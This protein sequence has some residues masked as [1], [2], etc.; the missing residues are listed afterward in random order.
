MSGDSYHR[1][2]RASDYKAEDLPQ[3]LQDL[4]PLTPEEAASLNPRKFDLD[5][6]PLMIPYVMVLVKNGIEC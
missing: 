3:R 5:K 1:F 2:Q 6:I 4:I